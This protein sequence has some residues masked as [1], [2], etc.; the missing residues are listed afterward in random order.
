[1]SVPPCIH[2]LSY[3]PSLGWMYTI[4]AGLVAMSGLLALLVWQKGGK[5]CEAVQVHTT[6]CEKRFDSR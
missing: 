1:M 2:H 3:F 6:E 4:W 5:W